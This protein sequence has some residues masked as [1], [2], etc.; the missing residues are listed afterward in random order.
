MHKEDCTIF[1]TPFILRSYSICR[2]LLQ[3]TDFIIIDKIT[4]K[5]I[6]ILHRSQG[7]TNM[8]GQVSL[9]I[10]IILINLGK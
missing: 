1:H 6:C 4:G 3:S 8:A 10:I 7:R 5:K 2:C 9:P